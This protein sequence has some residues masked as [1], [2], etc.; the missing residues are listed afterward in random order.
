MF[1]P[2]RALRNTGFKY[3]EYMDICLKMLERCH[4]LIL[5]DGWRQS[6]GACIE[7]GYALGLG[8]INLFEL[9]GGR[10]MEFSLRRESEV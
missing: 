1:N 9:I 10:L 5:I 3:H 8:D 2:E 6:T 7:A 4:V